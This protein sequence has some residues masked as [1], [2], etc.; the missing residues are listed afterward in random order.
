[1]GGPGIDRWWWTRWTLWHS[2]KAQS[3]PIG[4]GCWA[5]C[6]YGKWWPSP[7]LFVNRSPPD[8]NDTVSVTLRRAL[9]TRTN[10]DEN[11]D[12]EQL[13]FTHSTSTIILRSPTEGVLGMPYRRVLE[14][15][16]HS[17]LKTSVCTG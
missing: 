14:L 11:S 7:G 12:Y 1:M 3:T 6:Y 4:K 17:F 2:V 13:H 8:V 16:M 10:T 5:I 9:R 15:L